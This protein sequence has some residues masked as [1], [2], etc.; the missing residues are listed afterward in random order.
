M[1]FDESKGAFGSFILIPIIISI[2]IY[3]INNNPEFLKISK[4]IEEL[5]SK[6]E[7]IDEN[8]ERKKINIAFVNSYL[9]LNGIARYITVLSSLLVKTGKYNVFIIN[10]KSSDYDF[11]FNKKVKRIVMK[12]DIQ[13]IKD[14]DEENDI[15]IYILS[16]DLSDYIDIYHSL[17]KR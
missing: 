14:C 1:D 17:G 16:N 2:Y 11:E 10:E 7:N 6:I 4:K 9:Y 12:R 3:I 5:E 15:Q 13:A 8:S